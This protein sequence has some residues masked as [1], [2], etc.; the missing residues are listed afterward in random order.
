MEEPKLSDK[1]RMLLEPLYE[2]DL[3]LLALKPVLQRR[4]NAIALYSA[5]NSADWDMVLR[6]RGKLEMLKELHKFIQSINDK[7]RKSSQVK[8]K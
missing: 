6:N 3:Y 7:G 2:M 1:E 8:P 4:A 5:E